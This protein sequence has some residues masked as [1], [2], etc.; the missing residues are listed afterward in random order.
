MYNSF[1]GFHQIRKRFREG[2]QHDGIQFEG[3]YKLF[4]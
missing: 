4:N 2:F 3:Q 1:D